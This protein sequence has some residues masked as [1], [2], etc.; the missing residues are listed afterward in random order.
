V[1]LHG[2]ASGPGSGKATFF[3]ERLGAC[4]IE[5]VIPDLAAGDFEHMTIS[6]QL[7]VIQR[8]A[9]QG[10]Q[11]IIGSSMGGYLAALFA[12]RHPDLVD[13][14]VLM[15]PAFC[16]ARRWPLL[17]GEAAMAEWRSTGWRTLFH[18]GDQCERKLSYKLVEDG[19][20][21]EP[22]P[23]VDQQVLILHGTKDDVVPC[24]LS[25]EFQ[26][27]QPD[28]RRLVLLDSGHELTDVMESLWSES[29]Q[30][31]GLPAGDQI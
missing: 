18:Y 31:L 11:I 3:S 8:A 21:Y 27:L 5:T 12:A 15:A 23:A 26:R 25:E 9:G 22:Y 10:P 24:T 7:G 17:L 20:G 1:Y 2:F 29:A 6:S 19:L 16:F 4:G 30:F 14:L 13:R 28:T